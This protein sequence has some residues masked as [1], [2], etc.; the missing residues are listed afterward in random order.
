MR[1]EIVDYKNMII[2]VKEIPDSDDGYGMFRG[3][4]IEADTAREALNKYVWE[5]L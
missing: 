2:Q 5:Y 4:I 1:C 3:I